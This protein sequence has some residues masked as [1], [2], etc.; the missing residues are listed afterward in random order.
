MGEGRRVSLRV[1]VAACVLSALAGGVGAVASALPQGQPVS[2]GP[3]FR[4]VGYGYSCQS[5]SRTPMFECWYGR[6]YGPAGTPIMTVARG[7]RTLTVQTLTRP[8]V[9]QE[10]GEYVTTLKR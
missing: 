4:I 8:S 9:V 6:P 10:G 3:P 7:E 5:T 1:A 2:P